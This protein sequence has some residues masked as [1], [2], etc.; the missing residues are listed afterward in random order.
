MIFWSFNKK[1]KQ[2]RNTV[3]FEPNVSE[4][5][6]RADLDETESDL[7]STDS[8]C[9]KDEQAENDST[10]NS[11]NKSHLKDGKSQT[12]NNDNENEQIEESYEFIYKSIDDLEADKLFRAIY[13]LFGT[14]CTLALVNCLLLGFLINYLLS[15]K[16]KK[17]FERLK[18]SFSYIFLSDLR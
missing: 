14:V 6:V 15:S 13:L 1:S 16:F 18:F 12:S 8:L 17:N 3:E 9:S 10:S 5:F 11:L 7:D 4:N 2:I